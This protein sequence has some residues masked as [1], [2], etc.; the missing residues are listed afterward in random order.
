MGIMAV[1]FSGEAAFYKFKFEPFV[2]SEV[3]LG[4]CKF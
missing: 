4:A 1:A 3:S 2:I